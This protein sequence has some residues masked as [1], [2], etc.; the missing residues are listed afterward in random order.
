MAILF[1]T[2]EISPLHY[3]AYPTYGF[4][5]KAFIPLGAFLLLVG[6][7]SQLK[8]YL[9]MLRREKNFTKARSQLSLLKTIANEIAPANNI[10][11]ILLRNNVVYHDQIYNISFLDKTLMVRPSKSKFIISRD[12][13]SHVFFCNIMA[14]YNRR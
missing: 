13:C 2:L 14:S 6:V 5:T 3:Y 10:P 1:G 7:L 4:I 12:P 9:E 11:N 8:S